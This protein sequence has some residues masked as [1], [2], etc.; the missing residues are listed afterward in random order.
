MARLGSR[1]R[2]GLGTPLAS[3][4]GSTLEDEDLARVVLAAAAGGTLA[5]F[6]W[7][8]DTVGLGVVAG[9]YLQ[10]R[11]IG[12]RS[13]ARTDEILA[14]LPATLDRLTMCV[15]SGLAVTQSLQMAGASAPGPLKDAIDRGLA[16]ARA[17]KPRDEMYRV[18]VE[19]SGS[20]DVASLVEV[21]RRSDRLGVPLAPALRT[22]SS[23]IR[24]RV[25]AIAEAEIA[26]A[27]VKL[28]FPLVFCF[29]PAFVVLAIG[30]VAISAIRTLTAL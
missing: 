26:S 25:R 3:R 4:L 9:G 24:S 23:E 21:L 14:G 2:S 16:E 20:P 1:L 15:M 7:G 17:G 6:G 8:A 27:P 28:V 22:F 30:P 18:I 5:A 29:L 13:S 10:A 19:H 11:A 12:S